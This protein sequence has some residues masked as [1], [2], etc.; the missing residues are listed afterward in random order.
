MKNTTYTIWIEAEEWAEGQWN[1]N[2]DNTD[3]I[4]TFED[5]SR[6]IA[7]FYTYRNIQSLAEKNSQTGECL[8]GKY[9]WSS[10]MLL[11]DECSR[12]R[13]EEVIQYL[14]GEQEFEHIFSQ[15]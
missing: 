8:N 11:V 14:M 10:D 13:I 15:L 4:V 9:L 3:V 1:I 6:W 2:D 5:G 12:R 7:S